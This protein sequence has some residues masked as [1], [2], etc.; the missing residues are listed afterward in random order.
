MPFQDEQTGCSCLHWS[1]PS[2]GKPPERVKNRETRKWA[3]TH[4]GKSCRE[5]NRPL[6][7]TRSAGDFC[8]EKRLE[9]QGMTQGRSPQ[10]HSRGRIWVDSAG[11][12][13]RGHAPRGHHLIHWKKTLMLGKIKGR[14]RR[15]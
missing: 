5:I 11:P 12:T 13:C 2:R 10:G 3:C 8:V 14:R 9:G 1:F 7:E 15:G 6:E 4:H